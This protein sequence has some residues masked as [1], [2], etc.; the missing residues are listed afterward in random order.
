MISSRSKYSRTRSPLTKSLR[1]SVRASDISRNVSLL[2]EGLLGGYD[3]RN[4]PKGSG[5]GGR[6]PTVVGA[7]ILIRS[8]G[9]ISELDMACVLFTPDTKKLSLRR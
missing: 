8:M 5:P 9:P 1:P 2:L 7:D 6:G 3:K 4:R